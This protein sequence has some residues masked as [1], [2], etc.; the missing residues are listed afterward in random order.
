MPLPI[1]LAH[2]LTRRLTEVRKNGTLPWLR[3]DGKS[4]VTVE[5]EDGK[6]VA[7]DTVVIS[8]QHDEQVSRRELEDGIL[9]EVIHKVIRTDPQRRSSDGRVDII[10]CVG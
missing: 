10:P 3:P 7:V 4:Q 9:T 6:P 1:S 8:A 2:R 5:Y